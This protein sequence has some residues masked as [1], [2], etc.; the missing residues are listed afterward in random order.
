MGQR[1][2][3]K[4]HRPIFWT[5]VD[6]KIE[7]LGT[8]FFS[9]YPTTSPKI[10]QIGDIH[11][12]V[13]LARNYPVL[14]SMIKICADCELWYP[15]GRNPTGRAWPKLA[16]PG[17]QRAGPSTGR[18]AIQFILNTPGRVEPQ[19]GRVGSTKTGSCRPLVSMVEYF[20]IICLSC[21][22]F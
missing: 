18:V 17:I 1:V 5:R 9:W 12:H 21:N 8:I 3:V 19:T 11:D 6:R 2:L 7:Y 15:L 13:D 16:R 4:V 14:V 10:I 20:L 22:K